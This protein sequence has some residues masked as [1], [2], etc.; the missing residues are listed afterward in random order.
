MI[1]GQQIYVPTLY[2]QPQKWKL[3]HIVYNDQVKVLFI[4]T[5]HILGI[6]WLLQ[7]FDLLGEADEN[8]GK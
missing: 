4:L 2:D 7:Q 6:E 3:L 5:M 8:E 1:I